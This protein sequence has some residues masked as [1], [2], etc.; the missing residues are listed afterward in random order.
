M[1]TRTS[2]VDIKMRYI[3][4]KKLKQYI[5]CLIS[6]KIYRA[7]VLQ[8]II[9]VMPFVNQYSNKGKNSHDQKVLKVRFPLSCQP[10]ANHSS[11]MVRHLE[12]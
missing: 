5:C 8:C 12:N 4:M 9:I 10:N 1:L 11:T 2:L 6:T 3:K 7:N